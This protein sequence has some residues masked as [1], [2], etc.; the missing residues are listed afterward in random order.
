MK[1]KE[2]FLER[3]GYRLPT[4]WE[5]EYACRSGTTTSRYYGRNVALLPKYGA[6]ASEKKG[7]V[8]RFKPNDWGFFDML[9]NLSEWCCGV[10]VKATPVL[11]PS[12]TLEDT[13]AAGPIS[14]DVSRAVRGGAY[15][16][17]ARFL[18]SSYRAASLPLNGYGILGFRPARTLP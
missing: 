13:V 11:G 4:E 6:F 5:W 15:S 1:L 8:G 3:T 7:L 10:D 16:N 18:R 2:N 14:A 9:G 17:P 12:D